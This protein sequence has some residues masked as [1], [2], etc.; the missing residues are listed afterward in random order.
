MELLKAIYRAID[1]T[2]MDLDL[3]KYFSIINVS[4]VPYPFSEVTQIAQ[5]NVKQIVAD[6]L[7]TT[8]S[9]F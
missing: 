8:R 5:D 9:N 2:N 4:V 6:T 7:S 1:M 3:N